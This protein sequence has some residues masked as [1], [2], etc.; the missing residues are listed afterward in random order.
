MDSFTSPGALRAYRASQSIPAAPV[1]AP[2]STQGPSFTEL[3][4][5]TARETLQTVRAG[6]DAARAGLRGEISTQ[7]VI[8]A[9]MAM[10]NAI[11]TTV[12]VRDK[13]LEAYQDILR[14]SV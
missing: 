5:E 13:F 12:A 6:D 11:E 8:E 7:E 3:L 1:A 9:T 2:Q 10:E 14:M 4:E